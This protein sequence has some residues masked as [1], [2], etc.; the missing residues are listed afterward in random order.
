[1]TKTA[2]TDNGP[3]SAAR[4]D[5]MT[6]M[7]GHLLR[8][9][10]QIAV[11]IFLQ[12]CRDLDLTPVQFALLSAL[13][14]SG[15]VDQNRLGG[16]TALD[17]TTI[18]GVVAKLE[19]RGLLQRARSVAD[20]RSYDVSITENGRRLLD[21]AAPSIDAA[22]ARILSPLNPEEQRRFLGYLKR[23]ADGNNAE[24]RAPLRR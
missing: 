5:D 3:E 23:V 24:S 20:R 9:C 8:R 13:R 17:R 16:M 7:P 18:G 21:R 6:E 2:A 15:P 11:S 4:F 12:E 22:Q 19:G 1:V 14:R 10:Q